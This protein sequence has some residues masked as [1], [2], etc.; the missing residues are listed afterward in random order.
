MYKSI[1]REACDEGA[2]GAS[3]RLCNRMS[4]QV[5]MSSR[6]LSSHTTHLVC[7]CVC[8]GAALACCSMRSTTAV[9][10]PTLASLT[11]AFQSTP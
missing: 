2:Q 10:H 7:V 11:R 5:N 4:T 3:A 9:S 6:H 8:V 1:A